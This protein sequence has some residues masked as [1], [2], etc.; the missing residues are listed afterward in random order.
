MSKRP[1]VA[2]KAGKERYEA[3]KKSLSACRKMKGYMG[4]FE[5][6]NLTRNPRE[7]DK[8][9]CGVGLFKNVIKVSQIYDVVRNQ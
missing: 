7:E 8:W 3:G 9:R 4:I 2:S 5:R 1:S 6:S